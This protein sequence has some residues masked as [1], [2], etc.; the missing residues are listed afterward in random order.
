[1][2][3]SVTLTSIFSALIAQI[4][5]L[6]AV[7]LRLA[8]APRQLGD[9]R[10]RCVHR[11]D[12]GRQPRHQAIAHFGEA[13]RERV[14]PRRHG[15]AGDD[16]RLTC[17]RRFR[18]ERQLLPRVEER[19]ERARKTLTVEIADETLELA[20]VPGLLRSVAEVG[21]GLKEARLDV[22]VARARDTLDIR[23]RPEDPLRQANSGC[24][25][26]RHDS[27]RVTRRI[28]VRDIV[29]RDLKAGLPRE[30]SALADLERTEEA[31]HQALRSRMRFFSTPATLPPLRS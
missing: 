30:K 31:R 24:G 4:A 23:S 26:L 16:H 18:L 1:L 6:D 14:E 20:E 27:P 3:A 5:R 21:S 7:R 9:A 28:R 10:D 22:R 12:L 2:G 11:V 13:A 19:A 29:A 17:G 15:R 25:N 8:H